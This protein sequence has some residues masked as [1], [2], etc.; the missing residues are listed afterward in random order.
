MF[1]NLDAGPYVKAEQGMPCPRSG[2]Q[3]IEVIRNNRTLL[4]R[5]E[6]E[7]DDVTNRFSVSNGQLNYSYNTNAHSLNKC[8]HVTLQVTYTCGCDVSPRTMSLEVKA[9]QVL[10]LNVKTSLKFRTEKYGPIRA[11][12][13]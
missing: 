9:E 8:A 13:R 2:V 11:S 12:G 1:R 3:I 5:N 10:T 4:S 6:S 7:K